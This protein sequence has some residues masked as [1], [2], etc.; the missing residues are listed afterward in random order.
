MV[1]SN[2]HQRE[3]GNKHAAHPPQHKTSQTS[4]KRTKCE[5]GTLWIETAK[6]HI[7]P[8]RV[9]GQLQGQINKETRYPLK[10]RRLL[11]R[12]GGRNTRRMAEKSRVI[13]IRRVRATFRR[14]ARTY[15]S[16]RSQGMRSSQ[17]RF[18]Q[19]KGRKE[20]IK[21]AFAITIPTTSG[22][23]NNVA[24]AG[25]MPATSISPATI[26]VTL[27]IWK[28]PEAQNTSTKA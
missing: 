23:R 12:K 2:R 3:R 28:M 4:T 9:T 1:G 27:T 13:G 11:M 20:G 26:S 19:S 10:H 17:R 21:R 18:R 15:P 22:A 6:S 7:A 14:S 8:H 25:K 5:V 24:S 16:R